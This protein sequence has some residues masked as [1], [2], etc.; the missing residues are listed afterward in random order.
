MDYNTKNLPMKRKAKIPYQKIQVEIVQRP[1]RNQEFKKINLLP[2]PK[3][4]I[5][6]FLVKVEA[7][8]YF[9]LRISHQRKLDDKIALVAFVYIDD[10]IHF[11][12]VIEKDTETVLLDTY[13]V[14]HEEFALRFAPSIVMNDSSTIKSKHSGTILLQIYKA[15]LIRRKQPMKKKNKHG[16]MKNS[17]EEKTSSQEKQES[18]RALISDDGTK[19]VNLC[20]VG[21]RLQP[22]HKSTVLNNSGAS[23]QTT[24][25]D[26]EESEEVQER[27][28][29]LWENTKMVAQVKFLYRDSWGFSHE[30][31]NRKLLI[32]STEIIDVDALPVEEKKEEEFKEE[33][34]AGTVSQAVI[35]VDSDEEDQVLESA[36]KIS[37]V[38]TIDMSAAANERLGGEAVFN[39]EDIDLNYDYDSM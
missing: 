34:P 28:V 26:S 10:T 36:S 2:E 23:T 14:E 27:F 16:K 11:R 31:F 1:Q 18:Q 30:K 21:E 4:S 37:R 29:Y 15:K 39:N 20:V 3:E 7:E 22:E 13:N 24:V 17:T 19:T 6:T 25:P 32:R 5:P 8:H 12:K 9:G 35:A 38:S 33:L